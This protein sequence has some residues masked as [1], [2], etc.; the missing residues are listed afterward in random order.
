MSGLEQA[1]VGASPQRGAGA[2][3]VATALNAFF[4]RYGLQSGTVLMAAIIWTIFAIGSPETWL[5]RDIYSSLMSTVPV[6]QSGIIALTLTFVVIAGEIDL[7]FGSIMAV[8]TWVFMS[9][10]QHELGLIAA[11]AAGMGV[12]LLNGF[13]VVRFGIPSLVATIG[14]WF[15]WGGIV[16][17][18]TGSVGA[19][20]SGGFVTNLLTGR[21]FGYVPAEMPWMLAFA[22]VLWGLLNR[23]RFGA[24]VYLVGDNEQSAR[25][26]GVRTG[27]VRMGVFALNGT[28]AAF[29]GISSTLEAHYFWPTV[30]S[31]AML[32]TVAAVFLG[33]TSIFGG[34]GTIFG[35]FVAA[36]VIGAIEPGIISLN[37]T[38]FY[39]QVIYGAVIV[40]ALIVQ[41]AFRGRAER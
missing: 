30:G 3:P 38:G 22:F 25:M 28:A 18:G 31:G 16:I 12:G 14:S 1:P 4:R 23:H 15:F 40:I 37:L 26:M 41:S 11:L 33:G 8:G 21:I 5:H 27:R 2:N 10:P 7:S 20:T 24:H 17:V 29:A 9:C 34:R 39:T 36:F 6:T 32:P 13:I 19:G 35:T